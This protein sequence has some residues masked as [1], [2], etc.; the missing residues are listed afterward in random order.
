VGWDDPNLD[1]DAI[2][3]DEEDS[4][5]PEVRASVSNCDDPDMPSSTLRAWLIGIIFAAL[6]PGASLFYDVSGHAS[7]S[8]LQA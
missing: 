7:N 8:S 2:T 5:Y 3:F 1:A 4:P 6:I